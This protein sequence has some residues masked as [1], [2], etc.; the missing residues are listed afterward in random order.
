MKQ[1]CSTSYHPSVTK[2][3]V[4]SCVA[5]PH[6]KNGLA[7]FVRYKLHNAY[8]RRVQLGYLVAGTLHPHRNVTFFLYVSYVGVVRSPQKKFSLPVG[9]THLHRKKIIL[10]PTRA[11]TPNGVIH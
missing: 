4:K 3:I 8:C 2:V 1:Q 6:S 5:T 10:W 7:G 9:G 11:T